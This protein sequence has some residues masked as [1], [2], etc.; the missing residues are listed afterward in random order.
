MVRELL[1][2]FD[3]WD[4]PRAGRCAYYNPSAPENKLV[5][6]S[7]RSPSLNKRENKLYPPPHEPQ[8]R[9]ESKKSQRGAERFHVP[10]NLSVGQT[11]TDNTPPEESDRQAV[12]LLPAD[13]KEIAIPANSSKR[14][15]RNFNFQSGFFQNRKMQNSDQLFSEE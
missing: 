12:S 3:N 10:P 8:Q 11:S 6:P 4:A 15:H 9:S 2:K 5:N 14:N 13:T 1:L 7:P